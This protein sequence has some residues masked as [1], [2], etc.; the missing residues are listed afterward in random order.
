MRAPGDHPWVSAKIRAICAAVRCRFSRRK[1]HANSS[2]DAG[3]RG[4]VERGPGLSAS[5]PPARHARIQRSIVLRLTLTATPST[6][7]CSA[8]ANART[9]RPR[10][11]WLNERS[12]AW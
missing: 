1:Q 4:F 5:N 3:V 9:I 11:A 8:A 2:I 7:T 6:P 12:A 10:S